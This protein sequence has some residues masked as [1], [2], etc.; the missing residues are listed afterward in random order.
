M[1]IIQVPNYGPVSFPANATPEDIKRDVEEISRLAAE[2]LTYKPDYRNLGLGQLAAGAFRRSMSGLGSTIT[3][4]I[5]ALAGSAL[6]FKDYAAE[7]LAEAEEKQK[8]AELRDPTAFKSYK[9]VEGIGGGVGYVAE[10]LGGLAP[11][12]AAMLTGAGTG[13]VVG[14]R[15]VTKGL[16]EAAKQA[17]LRSAAT[18]GAKVGTGA[19]SFGL[20]APETFKGVY[21]ETGEQAPGISL[22]YGGLQAVLDTALPARI[23]NQ[24]GPAGRARVAAELANRSSIVPPSIKMG[25]AKEIAKTGAIEGGTEVLQEALGILAEQTAGAKGEFFSP[26]NVDRLIESGIKG[27]IGGTA[28]GAPSAY[29]EASRAKQEAVKEI[30]ERERRIEEVPTIGPPAAAA[31]ATEQPQG[32]EPYK[33]ETRVPV[34]EFGEGRSAEAYQPSLF[35]IE[36]EAPR[37]EAPAAP[38]EVEAPR[39]WAE[40]DREVHGLKDL[41]N[42][43]RV[44]AEQAKTPQESLAIVNRAKPLQAALTEATAQRDALPIPSSNTAIANADYE[45]LKRAEK[46]WETANS[47]GDFDAIE[48]ASNKLEALREELGPIVG[49]Q[50]EFSKAKYRPAG[51]VVETEREFLERVP[52]IAEG[53]AA[54]QEERVRGETALQTES[55]ALQRMAQRTKEGPTP[56]QSALEERRRDQPEI[57]AQRQMA[58]GRLEQ[59]FTD[60]GELFPV[61]P[62]PETALTPQSVLAEVAALQRM[63]RAAR[64]ERGETVEEPTTQEVTPAPTSFTRTFT[65]EQTTPEITRALITKAKGSSLSAED[66]AVLE[67]VIARYPALARASMREGTATRPLEDVSDWLY[68]TL[69]NVGSPESRQERRQAVE[70]LLNQYD[71]AAQSETQA[72]LEAKYRKVTAEESALLSGRKPTAE[73]IGTTGTTLAG[74]RTTVEMAPSPGEPLQTGVQKELFGDTAKAFDTPERFQKYLAS[75]ALR[76][77][78][79]KAGLTNDTVQFM[80]RLIAPLEKKVKALQPALTILLYGQRQAQARGAKNI[81]AA[82]A[83]VNKAQKNFDAVSEELAKELTSFDANL[84]N[85][86]AKLED[87][88]SHSNEILR[89]IKDNQAALETRIQAFEQFNPDAAVNAR[90]VQSRAGVAIDALIA[91]RENPNSTN[92]ERQQNAQEAIRAQRELSQAVAKFEEE[93]GRGAAAPTL[94]EATFERFL[95]EDARLDEQRRIA[96]ARLGGFTTALNSAKAA[97]LEAERAQ[98][99]DPARMELLDNAEADLKDAV[100]EAARTKTATEAEVRSYDP[101]IA[102]LQNTVLGIAK[103]VRSVRE[104]I[105]ARGGKSAIGLMDQLKADTERGVPTAVLSEEADEATAVKTTGEPAA[106][107]AFADVT[108]RKEEQE[109]AELQQRVSRGEVV[110]PSGEAVPRTV[111]NPQEAKRLHK[112]RKDAEAAIAELSVEPETEALKKEVSNLTKKVKA[113]TKLIE[114]QSAG[115]AAVPT[116]AEL[117]A[118]RAAQE[119]ASREETEVTEEVAE[120]KKTQT[121][122]RTG[123]VVREKIMPPRYPG[124]PQRQLRAE[125]AD[126]SGGGKSTRPKEFPLKERDDAITKK[127][128]A[129]A[130][131]AAKTIEANRKLAKEMAEALAA[132]E[133]GE[134]A[135]E[136]DYLREDN[137]AYAGPKP[138]KNKDKNVGVPVLEKAKKTDVT[139]PQTSNGTAIE[140]ALELG[141]LK[142]EDVDTNNKYNGLTFAEAARAAAQKATSPLRK[143]IL[144]RIAEVFDNMPPTEGK[145]GRIYVVEKAPKNKAEQ[146]LGGYYAPKEHIV[147]VYKDNPQVILHELVHAASHRALKAFPEFKAK[148][149]SLRQRVVKWTENEGKKYVRSVH[150]PNMLYGLKNVDEFLSEAQS[151]TAFQKLLAEIPSTAP[152]ESVF[153][154]LIRTISQFFGFDTKQERSELA[155]AFALT[156]D[157]FTVAQKEISAYNTEKISD[158]DAELRDDNGIYSAVEDADILPSLASPTTATAVM[159]GAFPATRPEAAASVDPS[160]VEF[161]SNTVKKEA[162]I[163]DKLLAFTSGLYWRTAIADRWAPIEALLKLATSGGIGEGEKNKKINDLRAFQTRV[164]MR[165]HEQ[166]NQF[167]S[168]AALN[169]VPQFEIEPDG[170]KILIGQN[171]ANIRAMSEALSKAEVGNEQFTE[172][173]F[174]S[175][176]MILRAERDGVGYSKINLDKPPTPEQAAAL[177]A[178]VNK[179]PATKAAFEKAR[180]IYAQYNKD[181][182]KF[183]VDAG[184]IDKTKAAELTD[185]DYVPF[186]REEDGVVKLMVGT[187]KPYTIGSV[188]EQPY[189]KELV[190]GNTKVLP[191][192][193]GAM[194]NTAMLMRMGLRNM[195]SKDVANLL[196]DMGLATVREGDGPANVLRF[197]DNG[198]EQ[199]EG[200]NYYLALDEKAFPKD[201]PADLVMQGLQGI[202]TATPLLVKGM[203]I[204]ANILR[205]LVTR[206]PLYPVRQVVR[207]STHAWLTSGGDFGPVMSSLKVLPGMFKKE[208]QTELTLERAGVISSNVFTGDAQDHARL[209]RDI[210][211]GKPG[212]QAALAKLDEIA[213]KADASTRVVLY[214]SFMRKGMTRAEALLST[215]ESMN[216]GRR[217]TSASMHWLSTM[218][219]FFHAQV[220]GLDA[221][222]RALKGDMP[223]NEKMDARNT[224]LKRGAMVAAFTVGYALMMQ[225]DEAYKNATPEQ[226]AANW[227]I[228]IPG[229][230]EAVRVPIPFELGILFKAIPEA[231]INVAMGDTKA[232][233]A[234]KTLLKQV[235]MANPLRP[236]NLPTAIKGPVEIAA[237]YNFFSDAPIESSRERALT[238][239]QRYRASTT[240]VAKLLGKTGVLSPLQVDH[241]VRSYTS[242]MGITLLSLADFALRPL[243]S[244]DMTTPPSKKLSQMALIGGMFQ[245]NTGRGVVDAAFEDIE[246]FQQAHNT[247][248]ALRDQGRANDAAAFANDFANQMALNSA[249]GKFR[250]KMGEL[251]KQK[252][253]IAGSPSMGADEKRSLID[254]IEQIEVALARRI[255]EQATQAD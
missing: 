203:A 207:D 90:D 86:K 104:D 89:R 189:L 73:L 125:A 79:D 63:G 21:E 8:K 233:E 47:T 237:N 20:Q 4:L 149:E 160:V 24:L 146:I 205:K 153:T 123:Q 58:K 170:T 190:G 192:F 213:L 195:Q 138:V 175:W 92:K 186:Y 83:A 254:E 116:E 172:N 220:Q 115:R 147:I 162:S 3:D 64:R 236:S 134:R 177:K 15:L 111:V 40:L 208:N 101:A 129:A 61:T 209:L 78:R 75:D 238:S 253:Q 42:Q 22:F 35:G 216:F 23:I 133:T 25:F 27:T 204:P 187:S 227:F 224:L 128:E 143:K 28:F 215:L 188:V 62:A 16:E 103:L 55:A 131:A 121:T 60:Q 97:R 210:S 53:R 87:A 51:G 14:R 43:Q 93:G 132:E 217:G 80:A 135:N 168:T 12:I 196:Q 193:A 148:I 152:K 57:A 44:L 95:L 109:R 241:L 151:N 185:G 66:A 72:P 228:R 206:M 120:I 240:E 76:E 249:G 49:K 246:K 180:A 159:R 145:S 155:H 230:S 100:Q 96:A 130:N 200:K 33:T 229:V 37:T 252:R 48:K 36:S 30:K 69:T 201:I 91:S 202:K 110:T 245:P 5:P 140:K 98:E 183:L 10:T 117:R 108:K 112:L 137:A 84:S 32:P 31:M 165:L 122:G 255:R 223:F 169:G 239:D 99:T 232:S 114:G 161:V 38:T 194:Q 212:W 68:T 74:K 221:T 39:T 119:R 29:T 11:D 173:M 13:A 156:D 118:T 144:Q 218:V 17:A 197:K 26:K 67:R 70:S 1:P 9:D 219:P 113:L 244:D 243:N 167:V 176:L 163:G 184:A 71:R 234:T 231:F 179:N 94:N 127:E 250:Q 158:L 182:M 166:T 164:N 85:A 107:R 248:K 2:K 178:A 225:D 139:P 247:Y 191:F 52:L 81:E 157:L 56:L 136:D 41:L 124:Q 242:N 199:K 6:G 142:A 19:A 65:R 226:R 150:A 214:D 198:K 59:E 102:N 54:A 105:E 235:W 88:R 251:A 222:Y 154:R 7:Q 50:L 211:S 181:L 46:Q 18:T 106:R 141:G 126:G 174:Q 171:G 45:R 82:N 34:G 77:L